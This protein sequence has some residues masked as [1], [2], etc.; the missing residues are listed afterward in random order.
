VSLVRFIRNFVERLQ[1]ID[2]IPDEPG[3]S[4]AKPMVGTRK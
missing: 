3:K 1:R 2:D 4:R